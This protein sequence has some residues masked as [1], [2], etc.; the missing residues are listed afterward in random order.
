[1]TVRI[2]YACHVGDVPVHTLRVSW[3]MPHL[4][5]ERL[6]TV[7]TVCTVTKKSQSTVILPNVFWHSAG[8]GVYSTLPRCKKA[9][10]LAR[11]HRAEFESGLNV[12]R[13]SRRSAV[14]P[15]FAARPR[16]GLA[17]RLPAVELQHRHLI[18]CDS[19]VVFCRR[20][21]ISGAHPRRTDSSAEQ[22][23]HQEHGSNVT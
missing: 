6:C 9:S 7:S 10:Q 14:L 3:P 16:S 20:L 19:M 21:S 11:V 1:M 17:R 8:S 2:S 12:A 15:S 22:Q 13:G 5:I 23:S 4:S 18:T